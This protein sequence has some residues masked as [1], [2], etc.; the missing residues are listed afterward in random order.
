MICTYVTEISKPCTGSRSASTKGEIVALLGAN[1]AGKSTT[2]MSIMRL[3]PPEGPD[4]D[5]RGHPLQRDDLLPV[6][7]TT[8]S[9]STASVSFPEGR[10]IFGNLTVFENLKL[11]TY[12]RKDEEQIARRLRAGVFALS[13]ALPTADT[14]AGTC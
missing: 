2:L 12:A 10:H 5:A 1:G 11:A 8:W 7:P 6:P 4:G 9:P 14:S 13:R 3:P